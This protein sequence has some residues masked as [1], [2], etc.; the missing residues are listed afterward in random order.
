MT[1]GLRAIGAAALFLLL[2]LKPACAAKRIS[3]PSAYETN[4]CYQCTYYDFFLCP[5][6]EQCECPQGTVRINVH[7]CMTPR[8]LQELREQEGFYGPKNE[9]IQDR[10]GIPYNPPP[11]GVPLPPPAEPSG[12]T[13]DPDSDSCPTSP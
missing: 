13:T 3:V 5:A 8:R 7:R 2:F 6:Y 4:P 11:W 12:S 1:E 9:T 10:V